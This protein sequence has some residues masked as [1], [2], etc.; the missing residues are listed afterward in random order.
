VPKKING[1]TIVIMI[2]VSLSFLYTTFSTSP[3]NQGTGLFLVAIALPLELGNNSSD[4]PVTSDS[5]LDKIFNDEEMS[6]LSGKSILPS[7]SFLD[8]EK[9]DMWQ[10]LEIA[11]KMQPPFHLPTILL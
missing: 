6:G 9:L 8:N 10:Q 1:V 4:V 5:I 7:H 3:F 2:V 11:A